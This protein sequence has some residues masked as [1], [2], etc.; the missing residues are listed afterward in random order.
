MSDEGLDHEVRQGTT[1]ISFIKLNNVS[2]VSAILYCLFISLSLQAQ[3]PA[4][5]YV[6]KNA[7]GIK[8]GAR[9]AISSRHFLTANKAVEGLIY[10]SD[11]DFRITGLY[12]KY[13]SFDKLKGLRLY[14]GAGVH[15]GFWSEYWKALYPDRPHGATFGPDAILGLD[16]KIPGVP[17]NISLDWQPSFNLTGDKGFDGVRGGVGLRYTFKNFFSF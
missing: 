2:K 12:E 6:Y 15:I 4:D 11:A 5:E 14:Y 3:K 16:L 13:H 10:L 17:V 9:N 1:G 8:P 7:L